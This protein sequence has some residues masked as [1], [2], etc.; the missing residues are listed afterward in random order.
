MNLS[1]KL[2]FSKIFLHFR[3]V[4]HT[5]QAKSNSFPEISTIYKVKLDV[6]TVIKVDKMRGRVELDY[7]YCLRNCSC[8]YIS[9][10]SFVVSGSVR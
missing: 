5:F 9:V 1:Y 10:F 2:F 6:E 3:T 7:L 8:Q 4:K